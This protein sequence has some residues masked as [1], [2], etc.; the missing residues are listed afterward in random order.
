VSETAPQVSTTNPTVVA[1]SAIIS[2]QGASTPGQT[3]PPTTATITHSVA[4]N[5]VT[6][7]GSASGSATSAS[8]TGEAVQEGVGVKEVLLAVAVAVGQAII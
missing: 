3:I 4:P 1:I 5:T 7:S 6:R 2:T 8:F